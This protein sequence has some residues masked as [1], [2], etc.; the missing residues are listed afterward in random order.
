MLDVNNIL[1]ALENPNSNGILSFVLGFLFMI[2]VYNTLLYYQLRSRVYLYY[3]LYTGL[4]IASTL[5]YISSDFFD[6]FINPIRPLLFKFVAFFRWSYNLI[7]FLFVLSFV[8]LKTKAPKWN[9]VILY[10]IYVLFGIGVLVQI[11]SIITNDPLLISNVFSR[12]FIPVALVLSMTGYYVL[13]KI[14]A[15]FKYYLIIG[16]LFL[17]VASFI[18]AAIYYLD[19]LP[20]DNHLRD[21]I[22]YIGV[23]AEN[24]LFSLGL[25]HQQKFILEEKN[26]II[27]ADKERQLTMVIETQERERARIAQEIHDGVLQRMGGVLLQARNLA[28]TYQAGENKHT[29]ELIKNLENSNHELRSISHQMMP[30]SLR[31]LGLVAAL[32]DMLNLSLPFAKMEHSFEAFNV[33]TR[34]SANVELV[35]FRVAQ[36]LVNNIVKH[37]QAQKVSVQVFKSGQNAILIVTDNGLGLTMQQETEGIGLTNIRSRVAAVHG[38]VSFDSKPNEGVTV[39]VKVPT[40]V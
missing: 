26:R 35:L 20:R 13:F 6:L 22:F 30:K 24:V 1:I 19:L 3:L 21:S 7:Y 17:I 27:L 28:E 40:K 8:D 9:N 34:F 25:A 15:K 32:D 33:D 18:G 11:A 2:M 29:Q 31:E 10:T 14:E 5:F 4:I 38:T 37:S 39:T 12:F 16:S 23:V 36:E